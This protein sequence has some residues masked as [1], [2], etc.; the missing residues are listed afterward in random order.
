MV[1]GAAASALVAGALGLAPGVAD[2]D[3]A[4][5]TVVRSADG[6]LTVSIPAGALPAGTVVR[7]S[8][9]STS[10]LPVAIRTR[11]VRGPA[12]VLAPAGLRFAKPVTITRRVHGTFRG[13]VPGLVLVSSETPGR[14]QQLARPTIRWD[15]QG[16]SLTIS[17]TTTHFS[18]LA[19]FDDL[20]RLALGP[21]P[22]SAA[23]GGSFQ[24]VLH[25]TAPHPDVVDVHGLRFSPSRQAV[26]GEASTHVRNV[27]Y[28]ALYTCR[29]AGSGAYG[30]SVRLQDAS[31]EQ[32]ILDLLIG[33]KQ[34]TTYE[35]RARA[36]CRA[37]KSPPPPKQPRLTAACATVMHTPLGTFPSFLDFVL[38][39]DPA[40]LPAAPTVSLQADAIDD[41]QTV[42]APIDGTT[43]RADLKA[44]I[45]SFGTYHVETLTVNG[46]AVDVSAIFGTFTVTGMPGTVAGACPS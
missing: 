28:T 15:P 27:W 11:A 12:Y 14:W 35:L 44:G 6:L 30:V 1:R 34:D 31:P 18:E 21:D 32:E 39:F 43:G 29:R 19:V 40:T 3:G 33:G 9:L 45:R 2:R 13:G 23:V 25:V 42:T 22:A 5:P 36:T 46:V 4:G 41:G 37:P 17:A 16:R 20:A 24:A 26:P 7:V 38:A 10:T 8:P